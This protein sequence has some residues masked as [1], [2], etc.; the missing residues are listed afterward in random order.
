MRAT[1]DRK[2]ITITITRRELESA[3]PAG[4]EVLARFAAEN[5]GDFGGADFPERTLAPE[6]AGLVISALRS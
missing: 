5:E 6:A 3:G 2:A 1:A 4:A